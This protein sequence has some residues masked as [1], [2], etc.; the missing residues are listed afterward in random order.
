MHTAHFE[1]C[2]E[3]VIAFID[4]AQSTLIA[5]ICW[6][7]HPQIFQALHKAL[8]RNV[9]LSLLL[10]YDHI[11]FQ[12][13]GLDF[14]ALEKAGATVLAYPGPGLLHH[15]FA[16]ADGCR[17]LTGSFNWTRAAQCDHVVIV[18]DMDL[19]RQLIQGFE[20]M[21][22]KCRP[23]AQMRELPPRQLSFSQLYQPSLWS[24][25]DLRRRVVSGAKTWMVIAK[26]PR[27]WDLWRHQQRH[28]LPLKIMSANWP[29]AD[30]LDEPAHRQW[31]A[32]APMRPAVRAL[33]TRYCLRMRVGDVLVAASTTGNLLGAGIVGASAEWLADNPGKVSRFVQWLEPESTSLQLEVKPQAQR[34]GIRRFCGSALELIAKM[35]SKK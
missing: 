8:A 18:Q 24:L 14:R 32:S 17:V 15:K 21:S 27:D 7:T 12:P 2:A 26:T 29:G 28:V 10:N 33:L 11:N 20:E 31:L 25:H 19:A 22:A 16:V 13:R 4:A 23:L 35:E 9:K 34:S 3:N 6:F 30:M 5:G 1:N